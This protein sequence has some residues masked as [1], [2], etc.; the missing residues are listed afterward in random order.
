MRGGGVHLGGRCDGARR[1]ASYRC[2]HCRDPAIGRRPARRRSTDEDLGAGA[3]PSRGRSPG[4]ALIGRFPVPDAEPSAARPAAGPVHAA[5]AGRARRHHRTHRVGP[6]GARRSRPRC[7]WPWSI[8]LLPASRLNSYPGAW[9]LRSRVGQRSRPAPGGRQW[10]E[11]DPW[12]LFEEGCRAVRAFV[13]R[14]EGAT[15]GHVQARFGRD[16]AALLDGSANVVSAAGERRGRPTSRC[17]R[18]TG[19]A[20]HARP[21]LA[22]PAGADPAAHPLDA[23]EPRLRV[24]RDVHWSWARRRGIAAARGALRRH[25]SGRVGV[26]RRGAAAVAGRR[27]ATSSRPTGRVVLLLDRTGPGGLVAGVLGGVGRGLSADR[28]PARR[29]RRGDHRARWSSSPP[30][31]AD[32]VGPRAARRCRRRTLAHP[33]SC[34]RASAAVTRDRGRRPPGTGRAGASCERLLGEVLIGPRPHGPPAAAGGHPHLRARPAARADASGRRRRGSSATLRRDCQERPRWSRRIA[35]S[36]PG[37]MSR[38]PPLPA[39]HPG[40]WLVATAATVALLA[41]PGP[42]GA[43]RRRRCRRWTRMPGT[44]LPPD[45]GLGAA[46]RDRAPRS[47]VDALPDGPGS[48]DGRA[49]DD[50]RDA[51]PRCAAMAAVGTE[52][53]PGADRASA[54]DPVRLTLEIVMRRAPPARPSAPG[55]AGARP[56]VAARR[57]RTSA[58]ARPPLVRP[59]G[60]GRLQPP[61]D[62]RRHQR[63]RLLR[64]HRG[65]VPGPRHARRGAGPRVP[66]Q[67]PRAATSPPRACSARTTRS[68]TGTRSTAS[69]SASSPSSAI[70]WACA[71]G[72]RAANSAAPSTAAAARRPA[73]GRGAAGLPA[74]HPLRTDRGAGGRRLHLVPARQGH[75]P[76]RGRVD[77]DAGR[78]RPA[79]RRAHP[80]RRHASSASWS[81]RPSAPS[82]SGSSWPA[83]RCSAE[84]FEDDN[85]HILKSD[86]VRRLCDPRG[87][88]PGDLE[89]LL[90]LDPEIER[91][92]EQLALF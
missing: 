29:E 64:P 20:C 83:R 78:A 70:G 56:L 59:R 82:W 92:A 61:L 87:G 15:G 48:A 5:H 36:A 14:L 91:Q 77:R 68:R 88:G 10:R 4:T 54:A 24:P 27:R 43:R 19:G 13:Q 69:W 50:R 12:L 42:P 35:R 40:A 44:T 3:R 58:A 30:E 55:G 71:S 46:A 9:P 51:R 85:W 52:S 62:Q 41:R 45:A 47:S 57:R 25:A 80:R 34:G 38:R 76:V 1:G 32:T 49:A 37:R 84:R 73:V 39:I 31:R 8:S 75:L 2:G 22:G 11:R 33:S 28:R 53:P 79:A 86:H 21:T 74:A 63:A 18:P 67:L 66:R 81:S 23:G 90:G 7:G 6:A 26:G 72:S 17:R 89:P 60:V 65:H 16:L